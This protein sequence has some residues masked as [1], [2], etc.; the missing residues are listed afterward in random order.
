[1][2]SGDIDKVKYSNEYKKLMKKKQDLMKEFGERV[3]R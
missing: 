1:M 3:K 2:A